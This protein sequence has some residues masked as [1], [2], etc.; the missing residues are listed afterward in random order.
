[1]DKP[2]YRRILLKLSGE[3]LAG[4]DGFGINPER[5]DYLAK[6][7]KSIYDLGLSI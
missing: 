4:Q 6:E 2:V 3:I 7:V 5:A 1:M